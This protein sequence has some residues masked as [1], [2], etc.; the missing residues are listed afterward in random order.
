M[1]AYPS[2]G[3]Q[4]RFR[5]ADSKRTTARASRY[6]DALA[7]SKRVLL[8]SV[9]R[10]RVNSW[11]MSLLLS[12]LS[13]LLSSEIWTASLWGPS[14]N[15]RVFKIGFRGW[16]LR[17]C[18]AARSTDEGSSPDTLSRA[19]L[20]AGADDA[21]LQV[22]SP[23]HRHAGQEDA[24]LDDRPVAHPANRLRPPRRG[25]GVPP[26]RPR[27]P[28]LRRRSPPSAR[29]LTGGVGPSPRSTVPHH[30]TCRAPRPPPGPRARRAGPPCRTRACRGS[31][32]CPLSPVTRRVLDHRLARDRCHRLQDHTR[33][34]EEPR[35]LS[36]RQ[37]HR[38][39]LVPLLS[40]CTRTV[41]CTPDVPT[42]PAAL[43]GISSSTSPAGTAGSRKNASG[44]MGY[45]TRALAPG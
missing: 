18:F 14:A 36:G 15:A 43:P 1:L 45:T 41:L 33:E 32:P 8:G 4:S 28:C 24:P 9:V 16:S 39:H 23:P 3:N 42:Y 11:V 13:V 38:F 37:N 29:R 19:N 44:S 20:V 30:A 17:R 12:P 2:L 26:G 5:K 10:F 35:A 21:V 31:H 6:H 34:W 40:R 25:R 7:T 27:P 22:C